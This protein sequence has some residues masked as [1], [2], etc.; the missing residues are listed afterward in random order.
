MKRKFNN[1]LGSKQVLE[2]ARQTD[3]VQRKNN[4]IDPYKF[5]T[6]FILLLSNGAYSL[7]EW[8]LKYSTE[9]DVYISFQAIHKRLSTRCLA[10]LEKM[11]EQVLST[12]ILG[13]TNFDVTQLNR[14]NRVIIEDSTCVKLCDALFEHFSGN[15][16]GKIKKTVTRIQFSF[17]LKSLQW[18]N[19]SLGTYKQTDNSFST[20]ILGRVEK[21]DLVLR[22]L[23]YWK[24]SVFKEFIK[25]GVYFLSKMKATTLLHNEDESSIDLMKLLKSYEKK[26]ITKVDIPVLI[27][28]IKVPVRLVGYKLDIIQAQKKLKAIKQNRHKKRNISKL[29][30][31]L[32]NW[33]LFVTNIE[34]E[35]CDLEHLISIYKLRWYIEL[36]FKNWKSNFNFSKIVSASKGMDP[37]KP[38]IMMYLCLIFMATCFQPCYNT[39]NNM[40]RLKSR[41]ILSPFKFANRFKQKI[42]DYLCRVVL[43]HDEEFINQELLI[44]EKYCSYENRK[45]RISMGQLIF[46]SSP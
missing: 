31:Y 15:S 39:F 29:A 8:A 19:G 30:L 7:R 5:I 6:S 4:K 35:R 32:I 3:F 18:I 21:G 40:M 2:I 1:F 36:L 25:Q 37:I 14:F 20:D 43:K 34:K 16:N 45:D 26:G 41:K 12:S 42:V 23:G 13:T 17:D 10:F 27:G 24:L 38:K 46:N 11:L 28:G 22:D 33:N 44:L 9:S